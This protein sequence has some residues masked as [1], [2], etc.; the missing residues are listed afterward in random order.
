LFKNN[1]KS[2]ENKIQRFIER[3]WKAEDEDLIS[4]YE[5]E[6]KKLYAEKGEIL[7]KMEE[8]KNK[9]LNPEKVD[10]KPLINALELRRKWNLEAKKKLLANIFPEWLPV[11]AKRHLWTPKL[12]LP[13]HIL[14]VGKV[15]KNKMVHLI[16][17]NLNS[18]S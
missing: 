9:V 11:T 7:D 3:I 4:H 13:Y 10:F 8:E 14:D 2:V 18:L 16:W 6:L 1:L 5:D 17:Q 12:S 15:D